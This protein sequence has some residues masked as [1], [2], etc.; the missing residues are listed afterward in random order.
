MKMNEYNH[1][2]CIGDT[3]IT[4]ATLNCLKKKCCKPQ[5]CKFI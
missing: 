4:T 1:L 2:F 3:R 5:S